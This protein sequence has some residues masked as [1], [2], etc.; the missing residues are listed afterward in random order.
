MALDLT[1]YDLLECKNCL[2]ARDVTRHADVYTAAYLDT[3]YRALV[4]HLLDVANFLMGT[5]QTLTG[6]FLTDGYDPSRD[7]QEGLTEAQ[8]AQVLTLA[9][10]SAYNA[11]LFIQEAQH[12]RITRANAGWDPITNP[13]AA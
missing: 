7:T 2:T 9:S 8:R 5:S 10:T 13:I 1:A 6:L 11:T 3:H 4:A 12:R